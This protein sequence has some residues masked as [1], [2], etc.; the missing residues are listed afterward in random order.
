MLHGSLL[1]AFAASA[2]AM[3]APGRRDHTIKK[4]LVAAKKPE[5]KPPAFLKRAY[6]VCGM[7]TAA[8]WSTVVCTTI[9]SNQPPGALMPSSTHA[10]FARSSVL[11]AV[12]LVASCYYTLASSCGSWDQ[13]G[14]DTCRTLNLAL[15]AA[16]V[17]S[18]LW[19]GFAPHITQIPG[20]SPPASHWSPSSNPLQR[21][22]PRAALI[23]A[24]GASAALSGAVWVRSLPEDVRAKPLTWPGRIVD[25]VSKSLVSLG[26]ADVNDPVAVKYSLLATSFALLT[27][28]PLLLP[29]PFA[30]VPSW[31]GRRCS[32]AFPTWTLL[33]AATSYNLKEAAE[34]GK[35]YT[36]STYKA[37]SSG[38]AGMGALYLLAKGGAIFIDPSFPVHYGIV[39]QVFPLQAAA[40][41]AMSLT[42]RPDTK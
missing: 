13:L 25:G 6:G 38:L 9:R 26:P 27:A 17:G 10:I 34:S 8:A 4:D 28:M 31:T 3:H 2:G 18:A 42:L 40:A 16:C 21:G 37:L 24:Y 1:I 23:G 29:F 35:L 19:V 36:E 5:L 14:S 39:R 15:A 33:A 7:A 32:R 12:P 20:S 41:T 11:S 22:L 30:V